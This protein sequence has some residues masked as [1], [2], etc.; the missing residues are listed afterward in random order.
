[1]SAYVCVEIEVHDPETYAEYIKVAPPS[2]AQYGGRYIVRGGRNETLEG[3]WSPRRFVILEFDS[4]EAAKAWW[5]SPEYAGPKAMRQ[6]SAHTR[7]LLAEG[8]PADWKPA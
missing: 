8:L 5:N 6:R 4:M 7:M 3:D 2:I 1:M